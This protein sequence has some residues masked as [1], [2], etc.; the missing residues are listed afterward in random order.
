MSADSRR[1]HHRAEPSN[2]PGRG[3]HLG[4]R[5][6]VA[7]VVRLVVDD[8]QQVV[9]GEVGPMPA[10]P[11]S[12]AWVRFRGLDGLPGA[13]QAC[14]ARSSSKQHAAPCDHLA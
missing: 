1:I 7:L 9:Q 11:G 10:S 13:V 6:D 14:L 4:D 5:G 8:Q 2:G 3:A 12:G